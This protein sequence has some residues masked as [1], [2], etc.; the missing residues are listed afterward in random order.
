MHL[1]I[2]RIFT[3]NSCNSYTAL[4]LKFKFLQLIHQLFVLTFVIALVQ[5]L[6][7]VTRPMLLEDIALLWS[8]YDAMQLLN[9]FVPNLCPSRLRSTI[10]YDI[11]LRWNVE[12]NSSLETVQALQND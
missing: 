12:V 8:R 4:S 5:A 6:T 7:T 10:L 11:S 1:V 2:Q 3:L 9:A